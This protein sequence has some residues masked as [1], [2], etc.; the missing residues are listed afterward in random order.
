MFL[1][2]DFLLSLLSLSISLSFSLSLSLSLTLPLHNHQN[3]N[4]EFK[5]LKFLLKGSTIGRPTLAFYNACVSSKTNEQL[6]FNSFRLVF[7]F[8]MY[9][10]RANPSFS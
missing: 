7:L 10:L 8:F 5:E 4:S 1:Q 6:K 2:I 3:S 9:T